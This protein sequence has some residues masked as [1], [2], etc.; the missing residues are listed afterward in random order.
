M[1]VLDMPGLVKRVLVACSDA[2]FS[3]RTA[4]CESGS[5]WSLALDAPAT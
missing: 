5:V 3:G 1:A 2:R 4:R